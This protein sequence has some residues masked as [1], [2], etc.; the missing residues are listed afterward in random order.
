[1]LEHSNMLV[2]EERL[3]HAIPMLSQR[4]PGLVPLLK[5]FGRVDSAT[6]MALCPHAPILRES[7]CADDGWLIDSPFAPD[8]V[9]A[10]IAFEGAVARVVGVVG[11]TV[12]VAEVLDHVVFYER[13]CGPAVEAQVSVPVGAEGAGVVEEPAVPSALCT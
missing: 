5:V 7:R 10:T 6:D 8:L 13:V 9:S 11:G 1:M 4:Q 2:S 12:L 3:T